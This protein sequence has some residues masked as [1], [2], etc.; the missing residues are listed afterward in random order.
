MNILHISDTHFMHRY[1]EIP[2]GV[3]DMIIHSGDCS[4]HRSPYLNEPEVRD[5]IEWYGSLDIKHKVFVAGNHDTSIEH[6]LVTPE[7]IREK[8]IV[9]L[10]N[11]GIEIDGLTLWGT[12]CTPEFGKGWAWNRK[13]DK[14]Y[15]V[16][17]QI[18]E[19]TD[20][21]ISHGPPKNILDLTYDRDN[22]LDACGCSNMRKA[23]FRIKPRLCLFG[24]IHNFE[25]ITNCGI[26]RYHG[27]RT[28]FSN[29]S[30]AWDG[31][32]G[33]QDYFNHGN[34]FVL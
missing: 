8:G 16:W 2:D 27:L 33:N 32:M 25:D 10:E 13:R 1:L 34:T 11:E 24:H 3:Y 21:V 7:Q 5:F 31:R 15:K 30:C 12:P 17:E 26:V 4:N 9:Y 28:M 18:P 6:R 19:G 14:M 22:Q 23:M 20:I 29:G